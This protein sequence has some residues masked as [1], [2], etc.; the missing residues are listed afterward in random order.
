M[1]FTVNW[2]GGDGDSSLVVIR[3]SSAVSGAPVDGTFYNANTAFGSGGTI[4][5]NE[6]VV[7]NGGGDSVVVSGLNP[8][9]TYHVAIFEFNGADTCY[10]TTGPATSSQ[11]TLTATEVDFGTTSA[12]YSESDGAQNIAVSI[13]NPSVSVATTVDAVLKSGDATGINNYTTQMLT[14]PAGSSADQNISITIT[15]NMTCNGTTTYVFALRNAAGGTSAFLGTDSLFTLT[16]TDDEATSEQI[17]FQGF[18]GSG[19]DNWSFSSSGG[20]AT[21]TTNTGTPSSERI[22][23][24]SNSF[25]SANTTST[26]TFDN[27]GNGVDISNADSVQVEV[28]NS[29]ISGTSG[30]GADNSDQVRVFVSQT[31][32]FS[33]TADIT[34]DGTSNT[35]YGMSGTGEVTTTAGTPV[36]YD[37]PSGGTLT[38]SDAKSKLTIN[39][40]DAW[41][42]LYMKIELVNNSSNEI[43]CIDDV[44]VSGSVCTPP[45]LRPDTA[46]TSMMFS[47]VSAT[48]MDVSWTNGNGT[49]RIVVAKAGSIVTANPQDSTTY[50]ANANFGNSDSL[51]N[52]EYI[53]YDGTGSSFTLSG[54]TPGI[55]YFLEV[56]E[57]N[58]DTSA[59]LYLTATSLVDSQTTLSNTIVDFPASSASFSESD[60]AQT[61]AVAISNPSGSVATTVNAVLKSGNPAGLN[62]YTTQMLTFPAGSSANQD[63]SI[64]I[65]DNSDCSGDSVYVFAL[66]DAAG[67]TSAILGNR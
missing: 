30:N 59:E 27:G 51:T 53:V 16:I 18:E 43:W 49:R 1:V 19:S 26:L 57:Y 37:Y 11:A 65:T 67:G 63:I 45:C 52:G 44:S 39:I 21:S 40:P 3:A 61:I 48:S 9:T 54:L 24:G 28:W 2:T 56:F 10:L 66:R 17:V 42:T 64:T 31:S 29:S 58:C 60:G 55:E 35:R 8:N 41:D 33:A 15:D 12:T 4:A 23:T 62:N 47:S 36:T 6:Y 14:F 22:R 38:G 5:A 34:L 46:A 13:A 25:Q 50:T 20:G 32:T 7:Y